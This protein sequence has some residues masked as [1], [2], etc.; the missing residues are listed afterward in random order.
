MARAITTLPYDLSAELDHLLATEV[1]VYHRAEGGRFELVGCAGAIDAPP[2]L[3]LD[4]EPLAA[5]AVTRGLRR[6]A[7]YE[8]RRVFS[9]Y[10]AR[11][12]ALVAVRADVL[13]VLGRQN[14]CLAGVNDEELCEAAADAAA[15]LS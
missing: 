12:A 1:F 9:T 14:G 7:S 5:Q 8:A 2:E 13:V 11:T 10:R 3:F 15:V 4:D 6:V